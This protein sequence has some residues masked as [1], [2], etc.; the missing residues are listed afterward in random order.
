MPNVQQLLATAQEWVDRRYVEGPRNNETPFGVWAG[1]NFQPW[2]AAFTSWCLDRIGAGIG[3]LVYVPTCVAYYRNRGRLHTVPQPGDQ[4]MSWF[5]S[6]NRYAHTWFVKAVEG[7]WVV[8]L[9]GNTNSAGSRTG[10]G[11]FSLRRKWR[12]T[13]TVFG[14]PLL[15][16]RPGNIN[17]PRIEPGVNRPVLGLGAGGR[18]DRMNVP[19]VKDLQDALNRHRNPSRRAL[20]VDGDFGKGTLEELKLFQ[21]A[22]GLAADGVAGPKTWRALS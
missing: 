1:V 12:G 8:T 14:R 3:K 7:D 4:G 11:C 22:K 5:P 17:P 21:R 15:D 6:K 20:V 18:D 9:E 19:H 13:R 10:G 16:G 2:C